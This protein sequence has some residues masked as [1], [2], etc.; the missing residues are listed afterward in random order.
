MLLLLRGEIENAEGDL[1]KD[2]FEM[3]FAP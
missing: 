2:P 1:G 3:A